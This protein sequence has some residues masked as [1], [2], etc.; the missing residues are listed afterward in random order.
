MTPRQGPTKK[1]IP[2]ISLDSKCPH[3]FS[4]DDGLQLE[5]D[6]SACQGA[7][8][9]DNRKCISGILN[10]MV[11]GA[12]PEAIILKRY[13]HKR[14]RDEPVRRIAKI[15]SNLASINRAVASAEAPSDRRCRTCPASTE[16]ILGR[17]RR[18]LLEDP[19]GYGACQNALEDDIRSEA[20]NLD[21]TNADRCVTEALTIC[22]AQQGDA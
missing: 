12:I 14:Y 6:C 10:V 1:L 21:C 18:K 19:A 13:I 11:A 22:A 2:A 5:I 9:I 4:E 8:D 17:A 20:S 16:R 15:A 3:A 7:Q